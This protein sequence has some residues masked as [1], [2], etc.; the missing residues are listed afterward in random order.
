MRTILTSTSLS[1]RSVARAPLAVLLIAGATA[2]PLGGCT[3]ENLE[4]RVAV[5]DTINQVARD[6]A[7]AMSRHTATAPDASLSALSALQS[8]IDRLDNPSNEQ[9]TSAGLLGAAI[10]QA[11][12]DIRT[13]GAFDAYRKLEQDRLYAAAMADAAQ[14]LTV[15]A[16][17]QSSVSLVTD[18]NRLQ[19]EKKA[20]EAALKQVQ[21]ALQQMEGPM[22]SLK[23]KIESRRGEIATL[24]SNVEDL[25][26]KAI[27]SG[28]IAG[29]PLVE[30]AA[31]VKSTIRTARADAATSELDLSRI[32]PD[33]KRANLAF[34]GAKAMRSASDS[35]LDKLQS[36]E[37]L[38]STEG[39]ATKATA[40]ETR[41]RA[42]KA[43]GEIANAN[44]ALKAV[45]GEIEASLTKA[46]SSAGSANAG[47]PAVRTNAKFAKVSAQASLASLYVD[48]AANAAS[49]L[50]LHQSLAQAGD[51][52]GGPAKHA[53][54]I[55]SLTKE[56]DEFLAKAKEQI[57]DAIGQI[58][59]AGENEQTAVIGLR[60]SL[61]AILAKIDGH[62]A[63]HADNKGAAAKAPDKSAEGQPAKPADGAE[64]DDG[65]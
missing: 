12:A 26:R 34:E 15:V 21:D 23:A 17:R 24:Q 37:N 43:I 45:F 27:E 52:F 39:T 33:H 61:N 5:Q 54:A 36:L 42:T 55:A 30:E 14:T 56:H 40:Q 47:G 58:G 7:D 62:S 19:E 59:E 41:D 2:L 49:Q 28:A 8:K 16:D 65:N 4:A 64:V 31:K 6:F 10:A 13:V 46:A 63:G 50:Q 29:L 20:A 51:L 25:R 60:N 18:K 44:D 38:L 22:A 9:R 1:L 53:E 35:G 3:D 57:V 32:E 11:T 48:Q